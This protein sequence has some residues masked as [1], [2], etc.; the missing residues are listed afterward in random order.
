MQQDVWHWTNVAG[1]AFGSGL[2]S[3]ALKNFSQ[4]SSGEE[5]QVLAVPIQSMKDWSARFFP[6]HA[7][8]SLKRSAVSRSTFKS[9]TNESPKGLAASK[10]IKKPCR[11]SRTAIC[12]PHWTV[13]WWWFEPNGRFK[14]RSRHH[15]K[16]GRQASPTFKKA[17]KPASDPETIDI[18]QFSDFC[19]FS[20][21][22]GMLTQTHTEL[23]IQMSN[24]CCIRRLAILSGRPSEYGSKT[25]TQRSAQWSARSLLV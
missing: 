17:G 23:I 22:P 12:L 14:N 10:K 8:R 4:D 9:A 18:V 20:M 13:H 16:K 2:P 25:Q 1:G 7:S 6:S 5:R 3:H 21:Q 15:K 19:V 11:V 24:C